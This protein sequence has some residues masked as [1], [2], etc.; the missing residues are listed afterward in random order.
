MNFPANN[1]SKAYRSDLSSQH[2]ISLKRHMAARCLL[3]ENCFPVYNAK[4]YAWLPHLVLFY[5]R[6]KKGFESP[7][8]KLDENDETFGAANVE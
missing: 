6:T 1:D 5:M 8:Q 3:T 4:A 2:N 7:L